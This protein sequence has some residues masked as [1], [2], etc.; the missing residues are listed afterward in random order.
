[1]RRCSKGGAARCAFWL[2]AVHPLGDEDTMAKQSLLKEF[3]LFI[4]AEKKWWLIPLVIVLLI[5]GGLVIFASSP[6]AP[7][8]YPLF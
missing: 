6:A 7:F 3:Y 1:M 2:W 5:V 8:L 4:V